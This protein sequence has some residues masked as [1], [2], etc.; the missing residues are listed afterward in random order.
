MRW[1]RTKRCREN[2]VYTLLQ[3]GIGLAVLAGI[4]WLG[5]R[6]LGYAAD[7]KSYDELRDDYLA[8]AAAADGQE[9]ETSVDFAALTAVCPDAVAWL[10]IPDLGISYPVMQGQD[11][12]YYL[13]HAPDGSANAVGSIF[14]DH[15]NAWDDAHLLVYGH[16]M[17]DG[18]MFGS[19]QKYTD[20][21]FYTSGSDEVLLYTPAETRRYKIFAVQRVAPDA[22]IYTLGF[23]HDAIFEEFLEAIQAGAMYSTGV[24]VNS[25]DQVLTLS[26]C[27][28]MSGADR[29]VVSAVLET[30]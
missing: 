4:I 20:E 10:E 21:S 15:T 14:L 17:Q 30:A 26:T 2:V 22:A 25:A 8:T 9:P 27:A 5:S 13:T 1:G 23:G 7:R 16:T 6:L 19:L 12:T 28:T 18:S 11:N 29:L 3:V 24:P